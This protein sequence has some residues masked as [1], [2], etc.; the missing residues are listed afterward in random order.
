MKTTG[1]V[2]SIDRWEEK[3][4]TDVER[5]LEL[6]KNGFQGI[7]SVLEKRE[8]E[9]LAKICVQHLLCGGH[10]GGGISPCVFGLSY[11]QRALILQE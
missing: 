7:V 8:P 1:S 4:R 2:V 9:G 11:C 6:A 10:L 5:A 3:G